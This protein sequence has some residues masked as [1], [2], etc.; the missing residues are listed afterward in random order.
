MTARW[1]T[2][3]EL[4]AAGGAATG[5]LLVAPDLSSVFPLGPA[6]RTACVRMTGEVLQAT[7]VGAADRVV[8]ALAEPAAT[9]WTSAAAD[10]A[11]AAASV[12]PRGRMRLHHALTTL[13]ATTLVATPTGVM[14]FLARLHL[15]FLLD[16][17]DLGLRHIVLTGEIASR[18][19]IRQLAGEFGAAVSEAYS[20]PFSGG[21]L[22][23]RT[24]EEDP[25]TPVADGVLGLASLDKD[26]PYADGGLAEMVIMPLGHST[27]G[28]TVLRTGHVARAENGGL[29]A[30]EHTVGEHV[31]VRGVWVALPRLEKALSKID[32]VSGWELTVSRAG[33][34]DSAV[35][36]VTFGRQSLVANPMWK[37]RIREALR[38]LTP[39]TIGVEIAPE[40][41]EAARPGLVNDLRGQHLGRDR[42]LLT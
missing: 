2:R 20:S 14:D 32:G 4:G 24:A 23:W 13:R 22:A 37:A 7:G 42:A 40:A 6:D 16:P 34:L 35:L 5:L 21:A 12:G 19:T 11:A 25:L 29:P 36:T 39:V 30:P 28:D 41:A 9:L 31:L 27:L 15:E 8:V 38:A 26:V 18:H 17:L 3:G 1:L 33:T 10:V